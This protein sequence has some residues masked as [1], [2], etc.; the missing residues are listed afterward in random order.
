[1]RQFPEAGIPGQ[2]DHSERALPGNARRLNPG[3]YIK[4]YRDIAAN[5]PEADNPDNDTAVYTYSDGTRT[6]HYNGVTTIKRKAKYIS[7]QKLAGFMYWDLGLDL[8]DSA[9]RNNYFDRRSLLRAANRYVSS[10]SFPDT[11]SPF[12]LSR[13]GAAL[14][15]EGG[16]ADVEVQMEEEN[17]GWMV[18]VRPEWLSVSA[19]SG[20]GR[21]T[22]VLTA[23]E[24]KSG[25]PRSGTVVFGRPTDRNAP[26]ASRRKHLKRQDM[27]N[28]YRTIPLRHGGEPGPRRPHPPATASST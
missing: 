23:G 11:P 5:C 14:P 3:T 4:G 2:Q 19:D 27:T 26:S 25:R 21:T 28:G 16:T 17:L 9:G 10:T 7:D 20:I 13:V 12:S 24:N 1:M 22:V 6:L 18:T 8:A 15:A